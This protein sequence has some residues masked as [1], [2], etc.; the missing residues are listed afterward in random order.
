MR[1]RHTYTSANCL[2]PLYSIVRPSSRWRIEQ[3]MRSTKGDGSGAKQRQRTW[4]W[5]RATTADPPVTPSA[6]SI[7]ESLS[8]PSEAHDTV[9][10]FLSYS[11]SDQSAKTLGGA[12]AIDI[13]QSAYLQN[14]QVSGYHVRKDPNTNDRKPDR[15]LYI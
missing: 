15:S 14:H 7:E 4:R 13:V 12:V 8:N 6:H 9:T 3:H 2:P 5:Q 10:V 11:T 1:S